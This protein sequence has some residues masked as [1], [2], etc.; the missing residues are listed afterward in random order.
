MTVNGDPLMMTVLPMAPPPGNRLVAT[1][2]PSTA[3]LAAERISSSLMKRPS[4]I[5]Q[6]CTCTQDGL[7]PT[8]V[9]AQLLPPATA[10]AF[11]WVV[12]AT[13]L[14]P[15]TSRAMAVASC[16]LSD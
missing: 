5:V 12:G 11:I 6:F 2:A 13:A 9:V 16:G 14:T 8:I 1:V 7:V 10:C 3:D 4:A 15:G